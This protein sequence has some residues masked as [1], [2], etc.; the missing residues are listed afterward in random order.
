MKMKQRS[1]KRRSKLR[2][3]LSKQRKK[4]P[5]EIAGADLAPVGW[6]RRVVSFGS[7]LCGQ[8]GTSALLD[9]KNK[10]CSVHPCWVSLEAAGGDYEAREPLSVACST[11]ATYSVMESGTLFA[12]GTGS[13]GCRPDKSC[14]VEMVTTK[15]RIPRHVEVEVQVKLVASGPTDHCLLLS[16]HGAVYSWGSGRRGKLGLGDTSDRVVPT[17]VPSLA[18]GIEWIGCGQEYSAALSSSGTGR[19]NGGALYTWGDGRCGQLGRAVDVSE[20]PTKVE[21]AGL[22]RVRVVQCAAGHEH[23]LLLTNEGTV[24]AWG[25]IDSGR[26]GNAKNDYMLEEIN[27]KSTTTTTTT[28][29]RSAQSQYIPSEI[30]IGK[31]L[32][33]VISVAAGEKHSMALTSNGLVFT[34]GA[35]GCG[36]LGLGKKW[37]KQLFVVIPTLVNLPLCVKIECGVEH[38]AAV[39]NTG[40]V[41][42]WGANNVGQLGLGESGPP[43]RVPVQIPA[44]ENYWCEQ[45][46]LGSQ[47]TGIVFGRRTNEVPDEKIRS[48]SKEMGKERRKEWKD[49]LEARARQAEDEEAARRRRVLDSQQKKE[50]ARRKREQEEADKSKKREDDL[51]I[52]LEKAKQ[53][54]MERKRREAMERAQREEERLRQAKERQLREEE[55]RRAAVV[56]ENDRA[57][58]EIK[59]RQERND[60]EEKRRLEEIED[61]KR[62]AADRAESERQ[63][64][65]R[66]EERQ[67]QRL[68]EDEERR[69]QEEQKIKRKEVERKIREQKEAEEALKRKQAEEKEQARLRKAQRAKERKERE[70][71]EAAQAKSDKKERDRIAAE[72]RVEQ[73]KVRVE[74]L[75][76][77]MEA[78]KNE[79][80]RKKARQV[81]LDRKEKER[82]AWL[83][84]EQKKRK[85][86]L[87]LATQRRK[88]KELS[89]RHAKAQKEAEARR[90]ME[91]IQREQEA[92][93]VAELARRKEKA[94]ER[95]LEK[96]KQKRM[97]QLEQVKRMNEAEE[98]AEE[99]EKE[100]KKM[101]EQRLKRAR[102]H[103]KRKEKEHQEKFI[104]ACQDIV[105]AEQK[106]VEAKQRRRKE[107]QAWMERKDVAMKKLTEFESRKPMAELVSHLSLTPRTRK[108]RI[109]RGVLKSSGV[110]IERPKSS[111][112]ISHM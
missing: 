61:Q 4:N 56:L 22:G 33:K 65:V 103:R 36:Q 44:L 30:D 68:V 84:K 74:R 62:R 49:S 71:R 97:D 9:T 25:N 58:R 17:A 96:A 19:A 3:K 105:N 29:S 50:E 95:M 34:W 64:K 90:Q 15:T 42:M 82:L 91:Q 110:M 76:L 14:V 106:I 111:S 63:R 2:S 89:E 59:E 46:A 6:T 24:Y 109:D 10:H 60:R 52:K 47:H 77:R 45:I 51:R 41:F 73:E 75:R 112:A 38:S 54:K 7:G 21:T 67:R 37:A 99:Q 5:V 16:M 66:D 100:R 93:E 79:V 101:E 26:L 72:R 108:V 86:A 8:L 102:K 11:S 69:L 88:K 12:W 43:K 80:A 53:E 35:N 13:L 104:L 27:S 81:E 92:A 18:T 70:E 40:D 39:T 1:D 48:V 94:R 107:A 78:K 32:L 98:M 55:E 20:T 31:G 85:E 83:E 28:A 57:E 87:I 23:V